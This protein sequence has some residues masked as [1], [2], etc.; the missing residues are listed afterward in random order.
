MIEIILILLLSFCLFKFFQGSDRTC[1][2]HQ[3]IEHFRAVERSM[4]KHA[5]RE[6]LEAMRLEFA[7][8]LIGEYPDLDKSI[9]FGND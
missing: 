2:C 3:P 4:A 6:Q 8:G 9:D 1:D 7:N 5:N